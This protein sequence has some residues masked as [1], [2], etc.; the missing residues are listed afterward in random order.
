MVKTTSPGFIN[1]SMLFVLIVC[2]GYALVLRL[3]GPPARLRDFQVTHDLEPYTCCH[4]TLPN[5]YHGVVRVGLPV[6]PSTMTMPLVANT[7]HPTSLYYRPKS[8]IRYLHLLKITRARPESRQ[9]WARSCTI[10]ARCAI[11]MTGLVTTF[12]IV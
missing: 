6:A 11:A 7:P 2:H 9:M 4:A 1:G 3:L 10:M 5:S 12:H 8:Q